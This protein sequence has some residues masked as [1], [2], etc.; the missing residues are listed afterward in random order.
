MVVT[1]TKNSNFRANNVSFSQILANHTSASRTPLATQQYLLSSLSP[2]SV[3]RPFGLETRLVNFEHDSSHVP[4]GH[5]FQKIQSKG[6]VQIF[7]PVSSR[8]WIVHFW[9]RNASS[10]AVLV[11]RRTFILTTLLSRTG[12]LTNPA[13]I[14]LQSNN[15]KMKFGSIEKCRFILHRTLMQRMVWPFQSSTNCHDSLIHGL[16]PNVRYCI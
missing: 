7:I 10:M 12:N 6:K 4:H 9:R 15:W 8:T 11:S 16:V 14:P 3:F 2:S 5:Y 1:L 13:W